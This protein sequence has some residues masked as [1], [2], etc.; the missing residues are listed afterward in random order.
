MKLILSSFIVASSLLTFVKPVL[1][2]TRAADEG[3]AES[4]PSKSAPAHAGLSVAL[5]GVYSGTAIKDDRPEGYDDENYSDGYS[6]RELG[7]G[8]GLRGRYTFGFGLGAGMLLSHH[9]GKNDGPTLDRFLGELSWA[10][11]IDRVVLQPHI[12][13]GVGVESQSYT[14][15]ETQFSGRCYTSRSRSLEPTVG[16]G[17]SLDYSLSRNWFLSASGGTILGAMP[18]FVEWTGFMGAGARI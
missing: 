12:L 14:L 7:F 11:S 13:F 17:L 15:C 16:A 4:V 5:L 2:E 8:L 1:A 3:V 10:F 6:E 9:F 18:P